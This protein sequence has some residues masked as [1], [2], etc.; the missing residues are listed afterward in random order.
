M[1]AIVVADQHA[2]LSSLDSQ[3]SFDFSTSPILVDFGEVSQGDELTGRLR[4]ENA[5]AET[6]A[7]SVTLGTEATDVTLGAGDTSFEIAVGESRMVEITWGPSSLEDLA[8][9]MTLSATDP[10]G[11]SEV[12][13]FDLKG[14]ALPPAELI[15]E[16]FIVP[17]VVTSVDHGEI[18]V[19]ET[20]RLRYVL[21]NLG[22]GPTVNG[23]VSLPGQ[24]ASNCSPASDL[25]IEEKVN[26]QWVPLNDINLGPV[27]STTDAIEVGFRWTPSSVGQLSP[28]AS[29]VEFSGGL[30]VLS[31]DQTGTASDG[32]EPVIQLL[33]A[34]GSAVLTQLLLDE[35]VRVGTADLHREFT[36]KNLGGAQSIGRAL[37]LDPATSCLQDGLHNK[38]FY[39]EG[40][41]ASQYVLEPGEEKTVT[42]VWSWSPYETED[43]EDVLEFTNELENPT[44]SAFLGVFSKAEGEAPGDSSTGPQGEIA[45]PD[46]FGGARGLINENAFF[47]DLNIDTVNKMNGNLVASIPLGTSW[48]VGPNFSYRLAATYNSSTWLARRGGDF[49]ESNGLV[50]TG[51]T[52]IP[53]VNNAGLGWNIS[54]GGELYIAKE[55]FGSN[56]AQLPVG[57]PVNR[58]SLSIDDWVYV[59]STGGQHAFRG[60]GATMYSRDGSYLRLREVTPSRVEV[61]LPNGLTQR[62]EHFVGGHCPVPG[63]APKGCWRLKRIADPFGNFVSFDHS[64]ETKTVITDSYSGAEED[65]K[66]TI[67]YTTLHTGGERFQTWATRHIKS[68]KFPSTSGAQTWNLDLQPRTIRRACPMD[69]DHYQ[70]E[71]QDITVHFLDKIS[72]PDGASDNGTWDFDYFEDAA[73]SGCMPKNGLLRQVTSPLRGS[74][75]YEYNNV[76]MPVPCGSGEL[77]SPDS[78]KQQGVVE[79]IVRTADAKLVSHQGFWYYGVDRDRDGQQCSRDNTMQTHI[80]ERV[81]FGG[82]A[83]ANQH[84]R[85]EV[86]FHNV[87]KATGGDVDLPDLPD[88]AAWAHRD[89]GLP[90]ARSNAIASHFSSQPDLYLSSVVLDCEGKGLFLYEPANPVVP[91]SCAIHRETYLRHTFSTSAEACTDDAA[92][93]GLCV[94]RSRPLSGRLQ[95]FFRA[96]E[97]H[98]FREELFEEFDGFGNFRRRT[99]KSDLGT[100]LETVEYSHTYAMD[101]SG[102]P[103]QQIATN[104]DDDPTTFDSLPSQADVGPWLFGLMENRQS[105]PDGKVRRVDYSYD[106][107]GFLECEKTYSAL[108]SG[109]NVAPTL[110]DADVSTAYTEVAGGK[111]WV[112]LEKV[113]RGS[114]AGCSLAPEYRIK[115]EYSFGQRRWSAYVNGSEDRVAPQFLH[116]QIHPATGWPTQTC[117]HSMRDPLCTT[118]NYDELG[119]PVAQTT[120]GRGVD[121]TYLYSLDSANPDRGGDVTITARD[122]TDPNNATNLVDEITVVFDS[123]GREQQIL[124][125]VSEMRSD[126]IVQTKGYQR[127]RL[128]YVTDVFDE[129]QWNLM[130]TPAREA[131]RY[132]YEEYDIHGRV[133]GMSNPRGERVDYLYLQGA[134]SQRVAIAPYGTPDPDVADKTR[135]D[136]ISDHLGRPVR[137]DEGMLQFPNE[138]RWDLS[139]RKRRTTFSYA[140]GLE[141]ASRSGQDRKR[142]LD[143]RGLVVWE[144]IPEKI[145]R[146]PVSGE[147]EDP[148]EAKVFYTYDSLGNVLTSRDNGVALAYSYDSAGRLERIRETSRS[149]RILEERFYDPL[150]EGGRL[151]RSIRYNYYTTEETGGYS[152][153]LI[154]AVEQADILSLEVHDSYG[155]DNEGNVESKTTRVNRLYLDLAYQVVDDGGTLVDAAAYWTYDGAN[156]PVTA[157]YPESPAFGEFKD[158]RLKFEYQMGDLIRVLMSDVDSDSEP[159]YRP[160]LGY[161]YHPSGSI[162]FRHRYDLAGEIGGWDRIHEYVYYEG[163]EVPADPQLT[164]PRVGRIETYLH[165]PDDQTP[166]TQLLNTM[167]PYDYDGRGQIDSI[168]DLG[169]TYRYDELRRLLQVD[170]DPVYTYDA[171]DNLTGGGTANPNRNPLL[172]FTVDDLNNRLDSVSVH[173][174]GVSYDSRGNQ[175]GGGCNDEGSCAM[176]SWYDAYGRQSAFWWNLNSRTDDDGDGDGEGTTPRVD[177]TD[178]DQQAV[179]AYSAAGERVFTFARLPQDY[180]LYSS[181]VGVI[182]PAPCDPEE[183]PQT[184]PDL[185]LAGD[186]SESIFTFFGGTGAL[187]EFRLTDEVMS[188]TSRNNAKGVR[189]YVGKEAVLREGSNGAGE[190]PYTLKHL[191]ADHLGSIRVSRRAVDPDGGFTGGFESDEY[192]TWGHLEDSNI[193]ETF[194]YTGHMMD[195]NGTNGDPEGA[196]GAIYPVPRDGEWYTVNMNARTY[197]SEL[198]RFVS[199]DP[200]GDPSA[201]SL[202]TYAANNPIRYRDPTGLAIQVA[203]EEALALIK[204]TLPEKLRGAVSVDDKGFI[205]LGSVETDNANFGALQEL[206]GSEEVFEAKTAKGFSH[207]GGAETFEYTTAEQEIQRLAARIGEEQAEALRSEMTGTSLLGVFQ[208]PADS[209]SGRAG[210]IVSDGTG[211]AAGASRG[212]RVITMAHELYGH[213]L[214]YSRSQPY[215]HDWG[216]VDAFILGVED[217]TRAVLP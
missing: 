100:N 93:E 165:I 111:G 168:G 176:N 35:A 171:F 5:S 118:T 158:L 92:E 3:P 125:E 216:S 87:T 112:K 162:H 53:V 57:W 41:P 113:A 46:E 200:A 105:M 153:V 204:E 52:T 159:V 215:G 78:S 146:N 96:G 97:V 66:I 9:S 12:H 151:D 91:G 131:A 188:T 11:Y 33:E 150:G 31:I 186:F 89:F 115:H 132:Q 166:I 15:L 38:C 23:S 208:N 47:S 170:D 65:R 30:D 76:F 190:I 156:R 104:G 183:D 163:T 135:S 37:N 191:T 123:M 81:P 124:R 134:I 185:C 27:D 34:D 32:S 197:L 22:Q 85:H 167:G 140:G 137:I 39:L 61:D 152:D 67:E 29:T 199:P 193:G 213:A 189:S 42:V 206:V 164:L 80:V 101:P 14:T 109:L 143:G 8:A 10:L 44:Q 173:S 214:L 43:F 45:F 59:D 192:S 17:L 58:D 56:L 4:V 144:L 64:D 169:V 90:I 181:P 20:S 145:D 128:D 217:R 95:R 74:I 21:R 149:N 142:Q 126:R 187:R 94:F 161:A 201:W 196:P 130:A 28:P 127:G 54:L 98:E 62:F 26:G 50:T 133:L 129:S 157:V 1:V 83:Q 211:S 51:M 82:D 138:D 107:R 106:D 155:Y 139:T 141:T 40:Q 13:E 2:A 212:D 102:E 108:M 178:W 147:P 207:S 202:Y 195:R 182:D 68:I 63:P 16:E 6:Q 180:G 69:E 122:A 117:D 175:T 121:R 48:Q 205:Q 19:G 148:E 174:L 203:D 120:G 55:K 77:T 103:L 209:P 24:A 88:G 116:L 210:V 154:A 198:G 110:G 75:H 99:T 119:R 177:V 114:G 179:Y 160:L 79:R 7:V 72:L 25:C 86:H 73:S 70:P 136:V 36:L 194:G 172:A 184:D 71:D 18:V 60:S 49:G 84:Y